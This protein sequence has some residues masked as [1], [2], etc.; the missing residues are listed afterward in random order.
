MKQ[1][2]KA[3]LPGTIR[4]YVQSWSIHPIQVMARFYEGTR[5]IIMPSSRPIVEQS[6]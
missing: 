6:M 5:Q 3:M 2:I 1:I 4:C